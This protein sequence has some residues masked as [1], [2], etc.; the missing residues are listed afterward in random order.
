MDLFCKTVVIYKCGH[1]GSRAY[2]VAGDEILCLFLN[3]FLIF[4]IICYFVNIQ[5]WD[6]RC[7]VTKG[8]AAGVLTGHLEGITF[9]DSRGDGRYFISNGKDQSIKLWDIRKMSSKVTWYTSF[10]CLC[11]AFLFPI[12]LHIFLMFNM[13]SCTIKNWRNPLSNCLLSILC[14]RKTVPK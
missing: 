6:R 4:L 8:Q 5:V 7:F 13:N 9:I 10:G 14:L 11:F 12:F 3:W 1:L 2:R